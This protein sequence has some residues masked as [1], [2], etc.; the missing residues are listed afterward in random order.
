ML[1]SSSRYPPTSSSQTNRPEWCCSPGDLQ[2]ALPFRTI[3]PNYLPVK[4]PFRVIFRGAMVPTATDVLRRHNKE[5][6]PMGSGVNWELGCA[7]GSIPI[8][9]F[10]AIYINSCKGPLSPRV[11]ERLVSLENV[12]ISFIK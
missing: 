3:A 5:P 6:L 8:I 9:C 7:A 12:A 1:S 11:C 10:A 2:V 4:V